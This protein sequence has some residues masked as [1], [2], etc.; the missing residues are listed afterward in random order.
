MV[1][2]LVNGKLQHIAPE[3][4]VADLLEQLKLNPK[5]LAVEL[6]RHVVSR[7][8]H[9]RTRLSANDELEIVTLVGGG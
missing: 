5:F 1:P 3:A 9:S 2:I 6:N 4:T 8:D 7:A